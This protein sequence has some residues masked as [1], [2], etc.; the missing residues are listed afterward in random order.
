VSPT[1]MEMLQFGTRAVDGTIQVLI[2]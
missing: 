1:R 2:Q